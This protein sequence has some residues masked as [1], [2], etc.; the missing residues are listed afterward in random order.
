MKTSV[1]EYIK[2]INL[3]I[4]SENNWLNDGKQVYLKKTESPNDV[5]RPYEEKNV[6]WRKI[7]SGFRINSTQT[8]NYFRE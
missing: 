6:L 1:G 4:T 7:I 8:T 3:W 5:E 2:M